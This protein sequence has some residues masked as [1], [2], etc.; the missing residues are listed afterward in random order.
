MDH[1]GITTPSTKEKMIVNKSLH[2][3]APDVSVHIFFNLFLHLP[4][5]FSHL[6]MGSCG[7][8]KRYIFLSA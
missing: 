1:E 3:N 2:I 6:D 5:P 8:K 7:V 4:S